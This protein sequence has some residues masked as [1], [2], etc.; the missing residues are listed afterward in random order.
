MSFTDSNRDLHL[1]WASA[2]VHR[3]HSQ[4]RFRSCCHIR[5]SN[6]QLD[7]QNGYCFP[8][9]YL[10]LHQIAARSYQ[11]KR[12][13]H[14][15]CLRYLQYSHHDGVAPC[16]TLPRPKS[17]PD[18]HHEYWYYLSLP[19]YFPGCVLLFGQAAKVQRLG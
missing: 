11:S 15:N 19:Q 6:L 1:C 10:Q 17:F 2:P 12:L 14:S 18:L 3:F 5:S 13:P 7:C 9:G 4:F 8:C 16:L